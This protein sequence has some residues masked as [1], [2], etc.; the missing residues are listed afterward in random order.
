MPVPKQGGDHVLALKRGGGGIYL[1]A[2]MVWT[3]YLRAGMVGTICL[4]LGK[5]AYSAHT[6]DCV[7]SL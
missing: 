2:G 3:I 4:N 7:C 1:R 5:V 6:G